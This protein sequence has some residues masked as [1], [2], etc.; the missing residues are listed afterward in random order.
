MDVTIKDHENDQI[1]SYKLRGWAVVFTS[2][3]LF[4]FAGLMIFMAII[5]PDIFLGLKL[6]SPGGTIAY[7]ALAVL[8]L[9][10]IILLIKRHSVQKGT[11]RVIVFG[12]QSITL[13]ESLA[14]PSLIT[15]RYDTINKVEYETA[16]RA[17]MKFIRLD[18]NGTHTRISDMGF[19]HQQDFNKVYS[20]LREKTGMKGT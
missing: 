1:F 14:S 19:E 16:S 13:P 17:A 7:G 18:H 10:L 8:S 12:A 9:G 6:A 15:L 3:F 5:E 20:L 4:I 11:D 2:I